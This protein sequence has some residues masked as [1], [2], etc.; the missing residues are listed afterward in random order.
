M[1]GGACGTDRAC[2]WTL[3]RSST[4]HSQ[5]ALEVTELEQNSVP[6][7]KYKKLA[8]KYGKLEEKV[9]WLARPSRAKEN[10]DGVV[11]K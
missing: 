11:I 8:D 5:L 10:K 9:P 6:V 2:R 3:D 1:T 7:E 4:A